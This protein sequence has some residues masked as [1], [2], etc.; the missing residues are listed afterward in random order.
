MRGTVIDLEH[1]QQLFLVS[2]SLLP[3]PPTLFSLKRTQ[4]MAFWL[5]QVALARGLPGTK[6][7]LNT[8]CPAFC[9]GMPGFAKR[10]RAGCIGELGAGSGEGGSDLRC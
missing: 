5:S 4:R 8:T 9:A 10:L 6:L 1:E 7:D 3:Q 2:S